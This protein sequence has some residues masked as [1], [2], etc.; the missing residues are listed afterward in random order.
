MADT[1]KIEDITSNRINRSILLKLKNNDER[2][3]KLYILTQLIIDQDYDNY[4]PDDGEDMGWLGYY[5]GQNTVLQQ[6]TFFGNIRDGSFY[7]EMSRN[8]SIQKVHYHQISLDGEVLSMFSPFFKNN[9]C[10]V[11]VRMKFCSLLDETDGARQLSL[12]IAAC[13]KSLKT[14]EYTNN[15]NGWLVEDA[16]GWLIL[17][18]H[19]VCIRN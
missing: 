14:F 17:L 5:I 7:K 1:I 13:S 12:A 8:T 19:L 9:N 10:L 15:R 11:E 16:I 3:D 4:N 18:H 2:F 6:L